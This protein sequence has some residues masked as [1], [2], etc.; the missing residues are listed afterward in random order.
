VA[1]DL[2]AKATLDLRH[3][4][5]VIEMPVRQQ[6]QLRFDALR[7]E[8]IARAIRCIEQNRTT[9]C[10][11]QIAIRLKDPAAK[12]PI[13]T[14][15]HAPARNRARFRRAQSLI[16]PLS[17]PALAWLVEKADRAERKLHRRPAAD[18]FSVPLLNLPAYQ[19][20]QY[21]VL[22]PR[23]ARLPCFSTRTL[24]L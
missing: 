3:I 13:T 1:T 10:I 22:N 14:R 6:Q 2:A 15:A 9:W 5:H 12:R 23:P 7:L 20:S 21:A 17:C 16:Q 8:P 18:R 11:E 4:G 19:L 24:R